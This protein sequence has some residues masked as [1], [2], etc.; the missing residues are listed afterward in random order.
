MNET[1]YADETLNDLKKQIQK[2]VVENKR[3]KWQSTVDKCDHQSDIWR[4]S[5]GLS[6]KQPHKSPNKGVR[7]ADKTYLDPKIIAN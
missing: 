2:L 6:G 3:T 1:K 7:L 5:K 4:F